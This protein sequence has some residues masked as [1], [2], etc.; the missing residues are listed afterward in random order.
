MSVEQI[1]A[2]ANLPLYVILLM[3]IVALWKAY[4]AAQ[5]ARIDDLKGN[6]E[7]NLADLRTRVML[8]E[9]HAGM[10]HNSSQKHDEDSYNAAVGAQRG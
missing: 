1:Q 5:N 10:P 8:L 7:R 4:A 9:D 2:L 6:Y 3:A